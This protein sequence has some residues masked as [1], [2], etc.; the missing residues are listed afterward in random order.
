MGVVYEEC[1]ILY[2]LLLFAA[3][4]LP[5]AV[6]Y[7]SRLTFLTKQSIVVVLI[8]PGRAFKNGLLS[9]V[10]KTKNYQLKTIMALFQYFRDVRGELKHVAWPTRGQ[11]SAFTVGVI[12]IS[13]ITAAYLGLFDFIFSQILQA[14]TSL[15]I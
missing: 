4:G 9:A 14:V 2:R 12:V 3:G 7:T 10:L 6:F 11:V 15:F 5:P 8:K 1:W 13:L